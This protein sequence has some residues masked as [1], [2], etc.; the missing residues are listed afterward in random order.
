M[1]SIAVTLAQFRAMGYDV[2]WIYEKYRQTWQWRDCV[3]MLDQCPEIGLFI[4]IE[5]TPKMIRKAAGKLGLDPDSHIN[6]SY[7]KLW[8]KH[9][10]FLGQVTRHMLFQKD[11]AFY[12]ATS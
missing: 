9:L 12:A 7:R 8:K 4:E 10:A 11:E 3:L 2:V 5:G 6:D 1:E